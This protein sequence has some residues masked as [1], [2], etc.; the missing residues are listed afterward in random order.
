[1]VIK[2]N[3][4]LYQRTHDDKNSETINES[5]KVIRYNYKRPNKTAVSHF[6]TDDTRTL[7]SFRRNTF[8]ELLKLNL[9]CHQLSWKE[10][11]DVGTP[12]YIE[13]VSFVSYTQFH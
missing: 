11:K 1:M 2:F 8:R 3:E 5:N 6:R 13:N 9:Y 10:L 4:I 12:S 7:F